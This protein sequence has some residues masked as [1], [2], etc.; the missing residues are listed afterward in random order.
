MAD[1]RMGIMGTGMIAGLMAD[2]VGRMEGVRVQAVAS[3]TQESAGAFAAR[4]GVEDAYASYEAL[5]GADDIDL[6]YVAS[7]HSHHHEHGMLA[8]ENGKPILCEKAFA[9]NAAQAQ[10]LMDCAEKNKLFLTEAVWTRFMPLA[11][12]I[13]DLIAKGAIGEPMM[14]T[15]NHGQD[16]RHIQRL[17][18]PALA[19]G[20]LLDLTVY[21]INLAAIAFGGDVQGVTSDMERWDTGVD[22]A[23]TVVLHYPGRRMA[24]LCGTLL[25]R[26]SQRWYVY[27]TE[28]ALA[29]DGVCNLQS[30][31]VLDAAGEEKAVHQRPPQISGYEYEVAACMAA[32]REGRT[33]CPEMPH[34]ET[35]RIMRLMDGLRESWGLRFPC[36]EGQN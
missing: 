34:A 26:M 15:A 5:A 17:V 16:L 28:G 14:V 18:D 1:L 33:E 35:M 25:N 27:G 12:L 3:R 8:L 24:V 13:Q 9:T 19:G 11:R 7:P 21:P 2:T 36:E 30:V 6:V 22:A 4:Y 31:R 10:A 23:E 29:I 20:A 32:L